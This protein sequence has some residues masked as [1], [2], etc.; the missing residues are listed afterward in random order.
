MCAIINPQKCSLW[1]FHVAFIL[2]NVMFN[3]VS[4]SS[5]WWHRTW[6][7]WQFVW[8]YALWIPLESRA[9]HLE[10]FGL[11]LGAVPLVFPQSTR[12]HSNFS[13]HLSTL[14]VYLC[15]H[16]CMYL[17][18]LAFYWKIVFENSRRAIKNN[19]SQEITF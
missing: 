7:C 13:T 10:K 11:F 18:I 16:V 12:S 3:L 19:D 4:L 5:V 17:F 14:F 9:S 2:L 6:S 1:L 8:R 15:M